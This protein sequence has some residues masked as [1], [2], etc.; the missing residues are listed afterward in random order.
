MPLA[1]RSREAYDTG[2]PIVRAMALEFPEE[3]CISSGKCAI[4]H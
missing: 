1:L 2:V 4:N 3:L